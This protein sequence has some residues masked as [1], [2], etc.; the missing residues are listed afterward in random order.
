MRRLTSERWTPRAHTLLASQ[1]TMRRAAGRIALATILL[2]IYC[3][4]D[5]HW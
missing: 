3:D 4:L 1:D 2:R 5:Y